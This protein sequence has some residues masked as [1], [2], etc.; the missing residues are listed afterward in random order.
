MKKGGFDVVI[1][2]PPYGSWFQSVESD[3]FSQHY[4]V[5]DGV[6]DVYA[7]FIEKGIAC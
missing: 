4:E 3:Y 2:N 7:C 6:R 5:F 1:G